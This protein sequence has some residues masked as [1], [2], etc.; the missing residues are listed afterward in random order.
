MTL[1][2]SKHPHTKWTELSLVEILS[3]GY[4]QDSRAWASHRDVAPEKCFSLYTVFK[5]GAKHKKADSDHSLGRTYDFICE[6]AR[7]AEVFV[8]AISRLC[9]RLRKWPILGGIMTH[10]Q[11]VSATC[12]VKV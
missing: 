12:W 9:T 5:D 2:W 10:A 6:S 7:D 1:K 11:F 3:I 4:G 8:V